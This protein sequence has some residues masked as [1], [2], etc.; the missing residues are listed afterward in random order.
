M[1]IPPKA[2]GM[3]ISLTVFTVYFIPIIGA[4]DFFIS[5][6]I[7][8][9]SP[10]RSRPDHPFPEMMVAKDILIGVLLL[11]LFFIVLKNGR[12]RKMSIAII[13]FTVVMSL[14]S[15][16]LISFF[17]GIR[18]GLYLV[19]V[20]VGY[21]LYIYSTQKNI[22]FKSR[23]TKSLKIILFIEFTAAMLQTQFMP[24]VESYTIL[25]SRTVG[26][27]TNPNSIGIFSVITLLVIL[28]LHGDKKRLHFVYHVMVLLIVISSGSRAA[29][30][31]YAIITGGYFVKTARFQET[32]LLFL[33]FGLG[34]LAIAFKYIN[35]IASK[36]IQLSLLKG[37]RVDNIIQYFN[38]SDMV[39]LLLG[40]GWG[41]YSNAYYSLG[42][43]PGITKKIGLD[44]Y[45]AV[46]LVQIGFIGLFVVTI[47]LLWLFSLGGKKGLIL[48]MVFSLIGLQANVWEYFP[49]NT[50]IFLTLGIVMAE[51]RIRK[52]PALQKGTV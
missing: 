48:F 28:F 41:I 34:I 13:L 21:N 29:T 44:S 17:C 43:E 31:L 24:P 23:I 14:T 33:T 15:R 8:P 51:K 7:L 9:G 30:I 45:Y 39:T 42:G 26:T 35:I 5:V 32:K 11:L 49:M 47:F 52:F 46:M 4:I 37:A 20:I 38:Y 36:P 16:D 40:R 10:G 18:Q 1:K 22:A 12:I 25:G 27:F 6:G 50:L 19:F 3:L 2:E